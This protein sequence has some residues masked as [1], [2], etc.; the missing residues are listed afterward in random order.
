M[1]YILELSETLKI[2]D[3]LHIS[4]L[5]SYKT[6][7]KILPP[8]PLIL[9]DDELSFNVERILTHKVRGNR[10]RP[11]KFYL[12]KWLGYG[13]EHNSQEPQKN[14]GSEV[15]NFLEYWDTVARSQEWLNTIKV[16][17][18]LASVPNNINKR[19]NHKKKRADGSG[20]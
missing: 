18:V 14:L 6:S 17:R 3:V 5:K 19:S 1:A 11:Q 13:F 16:L 4:L 9:E 10:M 8:P 20:V 2:H 7:S 15:L 12:I